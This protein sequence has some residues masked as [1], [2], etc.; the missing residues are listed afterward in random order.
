MNYT[1][2]KLTAHASANC[3]VRVYD[4]GDLVLQSYAT[5]VIYYDKA[6]D[7]V[8]C[9]GLYSMTTRKHIGW[10]LRE[11]PIL[12]NLSY[13]DMRNSYDSNHSID[14]S[15]KFTVPLTDSQRETL[16]STHYGSRL[17]PGML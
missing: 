13:Q 16:R 10:F 4:N 5:D 2:R 15:G 11:Y 7:R 3:R 17:Y 1:V 14:V 9:T 12:R 8:F 6:H